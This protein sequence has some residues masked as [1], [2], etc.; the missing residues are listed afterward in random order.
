MH[1]AFGA[2]M[3][4]HAP[5][6]D[7]VV[8]GGSNTD[9]LARA[10]RLP[11]PGETFSG[12]TFIEGPGG[13]GANQA[14]AAARLGSRVAFIS[15]V[16]N[17]RRGRTLVGQLDRESVRT[18]YVIEKSRGETGAAIVHVDKAGEKQ[19]LVVP[20]ASRLLDVNDVERA[21]ARIGK[22]KVVLA[23]LEVPV[24]AVAAA[25]KWA[26]SVGAKTVLD[27][28][29][30]VSLQNSLL[31]LVDVIKPNS[32]EAKALTGMPV[33]DQ[34]T[35]R[36][37]AQALLARGVGAVAIQAGDEGNLVVW[38]DGELFLPRIPMDIVDATGAGDAFAGALAASLARDR[39]LTEAATL[40]NAAAALATTKIG[41]QAGLPREADVRAL[42]A[43]QTEVE[44]SSAVS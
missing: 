24:A 26:R 30:P 39:S 40:A 15:A 4:H 18:T 32:T 10:S 42:V 3:I 25:F 44:S 20:G 33:R 2:G 7:V 19:V 28:A 38:N 27:P 23:Q 9:F 6:F 37:A 1:R 29:P 12:E 41:A 13:K 5:M 36:K 35:A 43:K 21:C 8:V 16:G 31:A 11:R 22:A 17:D 14:V 34:A